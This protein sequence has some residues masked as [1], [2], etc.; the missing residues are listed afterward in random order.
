MAHVDFPM[1]F[2]LGSYGGLVIC[3]LAGAAIAA[4]AL[5]R[6]RGTS[7]QLAHSVLVCLAA[8]C[9]SFVPIW[10]NQNRLNFYGPSLSPREVMLFLLWT[11]LCGWVVPLGMLVGYTVLAKPQPFGAFAG[12]GLAAAPSAQPSA[13]DDPARQFEPLGAGRAWG[14]LIP[15]EDGESGQAIVLTRQL[16]LLGREYDNDVVID[17]ERTSRHHAELRWDTGRVRLLD[18]GSMN[19]AFVNRQPARGITRLSDGD[20]LQLGA[21]RYRIELL[22]IAS[23]SLTEADPDAETRKMAGARR[24]PAPLQPGT[25]ALVGGSGAAQGQRWEIT[26]A[27]VTIGRDP[28]RQICLPDASVSRLH[29][30]VT[31]QQAGYYLTDMQSS[32]GVFVNDEQ[33]VEPRLLR[34]GDTIR[35]GEVTLNCAAGGEAQP[36]SAPTHPLSDATIAFARTAFAPRSAAEGDPAPPT[37][38]PVESSLRTEG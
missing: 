30:Q 11:V 32:N 25:L 12:L 13:L 31:R 10:W 15:L 4:H 17:D 3:L 20:V 22:P 37:I 5:I 7:R 26:Q 21:R 36:A 8:A 9:L 14:R 24:T 38:P 23:T 28:E 34:T 33:L 18:R 2:A 16:T 1:W 27:Q 19:G 6:K 35:I 29:A